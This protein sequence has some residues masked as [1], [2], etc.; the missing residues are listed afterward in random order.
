MATRQEI[1]AE[2]QRRGGQASP[3]PDPVEAPS[4]TPSRAAIEAELQRRDPSLLDQVGGFLQKGADFA[5]GVLET[6]AAMASGMLAEPI[7][8]I[9]G[10][11]AGLNP[12]GKTGAEQVEATRSSMTYQ[13]RTESGQNIMGTIGGLAENIPEIGK[14]MGDFVMEKTGKPWL[15][16]A[17]AS[18]PT[19]LAELAGLGSLRG[20][21]TGSRLLDNT[22][23]PTKIL[24]RELDRHG[25]NYDSLTPEAQSMIPAIADQS[26]IS[27]AA[28]IS[29]PSEQALIQQIKSGGRDDALAGV[30]VVR[31]KV[32]PDIAGVEALKQG[33]A[34]G[35]VQSVKTATGETKRGMGKMLD[36]SRRIKATERL[37]LDIRPGNIVGESVSKRIKFIRNEANLARDELNDIAKQSLPGRTINPSTVTEQL[38][39][40]LADLDIRS[41][42][43]PNGVPILD[44]KRSMISKDKSSQR[45]IKDAVDLLSEGG[46]VDA[47]RAHKLKRQ[48]DNI[49]DFKKKSSAGLGDEGRKVLIDLRKA[50]NKSVRD[51]DPDY[52]RVNDTLHASL[53]ALDDFQAVAGTKMDIFGEGANSAIGQKMRGL[54]SNI[55][56]RVPLENAV[57]GL[58]ATALK[59][60]AEFGDDIKDLTMFANALD[61]RF[62]N[63]AKTGFSG[64]IEQSINRVF[65]QG[66]SQEIM[67]QAAGKVSQGVAKMRGVNEFNAFEAMKDLIGER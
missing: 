63:V 7:A 67:G 62:G 48:L 23:R 25:L 11:I 53:T 17:A 58:D 39:K 13:P 33:Y 41:T 15:A 30:R 27:K 51:V 2:I 56:S 4:V 61:A 43:G 54:M 28:D 3:S 1:L 65:N 36:I 35:F 21:R 57:N 20:L 34:P 32:V 12:G 55:Q 5:G 29:G 18:A 10:I 22:G 59:L 64:Q 40:S 14:P 6:E 44:F 38:Q 66:L 49:I 31:D 19:L 16:T 47:L 50:L 8:G 9:A 24:R 45:A 52:A 46:S 60:G 42:D 26:F 37:S